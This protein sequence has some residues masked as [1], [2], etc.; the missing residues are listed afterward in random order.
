MLHDTK[1]PV[2]DEEQDT[3]RGEQEQSETSLETEMKKKSTAIKFE[4]TR[5]VL[6]QALMYIAAFFLTW[7]FTVISFGP[8]QNNWTIQILKVTFQPLQGFFNALI[9]IYHKVY[10]LRCTNQSLSILQSLFIVIFYPSEVPDLLM[11]RM[12]LVDE[13]IMN[14]NVTECHGRCYGREDESSKSGVVDSVELSTGPGSRC[15]SNK[16]YPPQISQNKESQEHKGDQS[17][18]NSRVQEDFV[19]DGV[20][21]GIS[22]Q[23]GLSA[24]GSKFSFFSR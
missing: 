16:E 19:D 20:S 13:N 3:G 6:C 24:W 21:Y 10:N 14:I 1:H 4:L 15:R 9:F 22:Y 8:A 5:V 11:S 2:I 7:I 23:S 18:S 12:E 17:G